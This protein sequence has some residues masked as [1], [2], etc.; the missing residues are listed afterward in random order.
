MKLF[1][2]TLLCLLYITT[3]NTNA[4]DS[5]QLLEK[6]LQLA[7][8]KD[9]VVLLNLAAE[10]YLFVNSQ[11]SI[12]YSQQAI[13]LATSQGNKYQTAI[14]YNN[15]ARLY[16][17]DKNYNLSLEFYQKAFEQAEHSNMPEFSVLV[18]S[19]IAAIYLLSGKPDAAQST[20][21][22]VEKVLNTVISQDILVTVYNKLFTIY[23]SQDSIDKAISNRH[24]LLQKIGKDSD[25]LLRIGLYHDLSKAYQRKNDFSESIKYSLLELKL[26]EETGNTE[27]IESF[28]F[29]ISQIYTLDYQYEKAKS[30]IL[31]AL[32]IA[33]AQNDLLSQVKAYNNMANIYN[34]ESKVD[35]SIVYYQ[36]AL[37][38]IQ[39]NKLDINLSILYNNLG[40]SYKE[41]GDFDNAIK[42][43]RLALDQK[44][45]AKDDNLF[46]PLTTIAEIYLKKNM[47]KESFEYAQQANYIALETKNPMQLLG[48]YKLFYELYYQKEEYKLALDNYRLY[49]EL[50]DSLSDQKMN[51]T[52][53]ELEIKYQANKKEQES[54]LLEQKNVIQRNSF[55]ALAVMFLLMIFF[56]YSKYINKKKAN[57]ELQ[58]KNEKI[59]QQ[60]KQLEEAMS[61][62]QE[63]EKG[64]IEAN[65]TKDKFFSIIAHD[66]KNPLHAIVLSSDLLL[67]RFKSMTGEQLVDLINS[68]NKAG[69]H[70]SNLL[71][72]LLNWARAQSNK[73]NVAAE[74]FEINDVLDNVIGLQNVN[75]EEKSVKIINNLEAKHVVFFDK[76]M[77]KTVLRNLISNAI[78]FSFAQSSVVVAAE[79]E[80]S[81]LK[82][83]I[84]DSGVGMKPEDIDKLFRIDIHHSTKGTNAESGTG[85]GL[86]LCKD[87]VEMNGGSI[88]VESTF[89]EGTTFTIFLPMEDVN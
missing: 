34:K 86:L 22:E 83:S 40:V 3:Y 58:S 87:F 31:L 26:K 59:N 48:I 35:S 42:Y 67:N 5:L 84:S 7:N 4:L 41:I 9:K 20:I 12:D 73:I 45:A 6:Q 15:I 79:Q 71:E 30:H 60:H 32:E 89:G 74:Y 82:L 23:Y 17:Y 76:N 2:L 19:N 25:I 14:A 66:L 13:K 21:L 64:L 61:D 75:A 72:N 49:V 43:C 16:Q 27:D 39:N 36:K 8:T 55:I 52:I 80:N 1:L 18:K 44:I 11:K 28:H 70:L 38:L 47:L 53:A 85:L 77:L 51:K 10:K 88:R 24:A 57:E 69:L 56:I 46:F 37:S 54:R 81:N 29:K 78:K 63:K 68:I 33:I 62:L 65:I 50:N